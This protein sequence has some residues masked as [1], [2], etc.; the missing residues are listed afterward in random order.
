MYTFTDCITE[1]SNTQVDPAKD[2][3]FAVT[4]MYNLIEHIDDYSKSSGCLY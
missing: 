3:G 1:I 2:F 4:Q